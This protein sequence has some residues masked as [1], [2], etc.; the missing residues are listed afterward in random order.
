MN[1]PKKLAHALKLSAIRAAKVAL[2]I[3]DQGHLDTRRKLDN[4]PVS[5][6]DLAANREI[7]DVL[8]DVFPSTPIVSEEST[9]PRMDPEEPY[10]LVDPIDG[11]REYIAG[12]S[13][14][15]VNVALIRDQ[16]P[17][18]G[19]VLAPAKRLGFMATGT[20][21]TEVLAFGD[22]IDSCSTRPLRFPPHADAVRTAAVSRSHLDA[23]TRTWLEKHPYDKRM[24][25]G[26]SWK[27]CLLADGAAAVYPR[28]APT[29]TWDIA[30]GHA[31]LVAA[32]GRVTQPDGGSPIRYGSE[33]LT[34]PA[35]I[36]F[37]PGH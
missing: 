34:V 6:G 19:I 21:S 37:A 5:A 28:L 23:A 9:F 32:G 35:F 20:G 7:C 22:V 18:A 1:D 15:T 10:F 33:D 29:N 30:A 17:V 2:T 13:E 36:A 26:S 31:I 8:A 25:C 11:T 16:V 27:F 4:S 14:F 12:G 24:R 3:R